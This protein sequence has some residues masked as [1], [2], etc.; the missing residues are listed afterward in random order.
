MPLDIA[1]YG[2]NGHFSPYEV[3]LLVCGLSKAV[4]RKSWEVLPF[5]SEEAYQQ[6]MSDMAVRI[7]NTL[8]WLKLQEDHKIYFNNTI[9]LKR[10][11]KIQLKLAKQRSQ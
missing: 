11:E 9:M 3:K 5:S 4:F 1:S 7:G 6:E 8:Y 2:L 10:A